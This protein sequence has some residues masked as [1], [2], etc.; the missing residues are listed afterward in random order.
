MAFTKHLIY[1]NNY[2]A[3][4]VFTQA[5]AFKGANSNQVLAKKQSVV[6]LKA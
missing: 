4:G 6:R 5:H 3:R 2:P 1:M